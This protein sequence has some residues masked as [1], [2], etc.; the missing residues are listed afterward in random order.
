MAMH[1]LLILN[2]EKGNSRIIVRLRHK[3]MKDRVVSLLGDDKNREAFDLLKSKA[4]V[5]VYLPP[6]AKLPFTPQ[7]TLVEDLI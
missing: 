1:A 7:V 5:E 2:E 4:E 6:G 3:Q